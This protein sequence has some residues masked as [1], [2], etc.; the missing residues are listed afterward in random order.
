MIV[1]K[2]FFVVLIAALMTLS[3]CG[4]FKKKCD[5]PHVGYKKPAEVTDR[6][7]SKK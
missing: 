1:R 2:K 6:A 7:M 5:C 3:G 4:I